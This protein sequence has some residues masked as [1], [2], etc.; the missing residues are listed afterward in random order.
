MTD[1]NNEVKTEP[2]F[3]SSVST[4]K[5]VLALICIAAL[6]V[7]GVVLIPVFFGS[8]QAEI[9]EETKASNASYAAA[10]ELAVQTVSKSVTYDEYRS[11]AISSL[12]TDVDV[13]F[14]VPFS[15]EDKL[16]IFKFSFSEGS[17][18]TA[19][20]D[21]G[22]LD[23]YGELSQKVMYPTAETDSIPTDVLLA[24]VPEG[25]AKCEMTLDCDGKKYTLNIKALDS[26]EYTVKVS[27][28]K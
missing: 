13:E 25:E 22:K 7:I 20:V 16:A 5:R 19:T 28:V 18:I 9:N 12:L 11:D 4:F 24:W 8:R 14:K 17:G 26:N 23:L 2:V 6:L 15:T 10:A 3:V 27:A 21:K 1:E